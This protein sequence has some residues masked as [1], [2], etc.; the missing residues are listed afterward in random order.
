MHK[1][2]IPCC[3]STN[4][5]FKLT[6]DLYCRILVSSIDPW[7]HQRVV[8]GG[9]GREEVGHRDAMYVYYLLVFYYKKI[10]LFSFI[11]CKRY[12]EFKKQCS[13]QKWYQQN[14]LYVYICNWL[15]SFSTSYDSPVPVR[16]GGQNTDNSLSKNTTFL[17][18]PVCIIHV[19][20]M[21]PDQYMSSSYSMYLLTK[22]QTRY[23]NCKLARNIKRI[24][25]S[26]IIFTSLIIRKTAILWKF[27]T[28]CT[29]Y[30]HIYHDRKPNRPGSH[31]Q[32]KR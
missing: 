9:N 28:P 21:E 17:S 15:S 14:T 31:R 19:A 16:E 23:T 11:W 22:L 5:S 13:F 24:F 26:N 10:S 1:I 20:Y 27:G 25:S 8:R 6:S 2:D 30:L 12:K 32:T 4:L 18:N 3:Q 7:V 29:W